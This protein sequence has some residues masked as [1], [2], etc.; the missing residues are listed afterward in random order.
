MKFT[1]ITLSLTSFALFLTGCGVVADQ[2]SSDGT[3]LELAGVGAT[4]RASLKRAADS[5]LSEFSESQYVTAFHRL[6]TNY[7]GLTDAARQAERMAATM[8][9]GEEKLAEH[10]GPPIKGSFVYVGSISVGSRLLKLAYIRRH[11]DGPVAIVLVFTRPDH[12]WIFTD[13]GVGEGT[14]PEM[15]ALYCRI[16]PSDLIEQM[17]E[18][19]SILRNVDACMKSWSVGD[20]R[21]GAEMLFRRSAVEQSDLRVESLLDQTVKFV[22]GIPAKIGA[23][24]GYELVGVFN[25]S[26]DMIKLVYVW[27]F[28]KQHAPVAFEFYHSPDGWKLWRLRLFDKAREDMFAASIDKPVALRDLSHTEDEVTDDWKN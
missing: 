27:R 17:P 28:E 16:A 15:R 4:D 3:A 7:T 8:A 24:K 19:E 1:Y 6:L 23:S 10:I 13:I 25:Q 20:S 21:G 9:D 22:E 5:F 2:P 26:A 18:T 14:D 12:Q 11:Q